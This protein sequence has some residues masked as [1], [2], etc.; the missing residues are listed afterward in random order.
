MHGRSASRLSFYL[1]PFLRDFVVEK[2]INQPFCALFCP[3]L[4]KKGTADAADRENK[5]GP[6]QSVQPAVK[7]GSIWILSACLYGIPELCVLFLKSVGCEVNF[8]CAE[9]FCVRIVVLVAGDLRIEHVLS[10]GVRC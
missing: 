3:F 5:N 10:C 7:T 2:G 1:V 6:H 8:Q 9:Y 4:K